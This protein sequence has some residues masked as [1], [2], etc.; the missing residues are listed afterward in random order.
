MLI[1]YLAFLFFY[2]IFNN[3]GFSISVEKRITPLNAVQYYFEDST[4][5][6]TIADILDTNQ[7]FLFKGDKNFS[8]SYSKCRFWGKF[9]VENNTDTV[10][11]LLAMM[12]SAA[13]NQVAFYQVKK[14]HIIDS[15]VMGVDFPF[16]SRQLY[17]HN[18]AF[19]F[20][21]NPKDSCTIYWMMQNKNGTLN[22]HFLLMSFSKFQRTYGQK[23][24]IL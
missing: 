4:R 8:P 14:Q 21:L 12:T 2:A 20:S 22:T 23:N 18:Y 5:S 15:T 11:E 7:Y 17:N 1:R 13:F 16:S 10:Q 6:I 3:S 9:L 24:I 19:K